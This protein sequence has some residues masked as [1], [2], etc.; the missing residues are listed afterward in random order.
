MRLTSDVAVVGGGQFGF[1]ISSPL[2]CHVYLL[3]GGDEL[4]LIDAGM[5]GAIGDTEKIL[6]NIRDDGYDPARISK[7]LLTHYHADHAGGAAELYAALGV[8]I[9]GSPLTA[10]TLER[11]DE[12]QISL[13]VA[14]A[15]G[16]YP[17]D[18]V[19]QACPA[20]GDFIDGASFMV[21]SLRITTYD[22][23]GHSDGHVSFLVE[24]GE[25]SYLIEGDVVFFG[26]LILL[27]NIADCSIQK[28]AASVE[29][30]ASLEFDAL[31]PGHLTVSL[32]DGRRHIDA[33]AAVFR[34][35]LVP[36]NL[37]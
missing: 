26:G 20:S 31:L 16:L 23:P 19:F 3:D 8:P 17:D 11:G 28:Y 5:G 14:K 22:T 24:G 18:Y 4:A 13:P 10:T 7:V 9:I 30:L 15:A 34:K 37:F 2:D 25:R 1:G 12:E 6:Q 36:K 27:Q 21:G 33:A 32:T 29:K 35:L